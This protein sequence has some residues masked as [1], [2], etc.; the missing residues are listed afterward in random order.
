MRYISRLTLLLSLSVLSLPSS[1]ATS[2][3]QFDDALLTTPASPE[4]IA[5]GLEADGYQLG[6]SAYSW[7][8]PLVRMERVL[9]DYSDV[10]SEVPAT[11][12]RAPIS[13]IGWARELAS[14]SAKDMPTANNDTFYMS[15]VVILDEPFVLSVPD[16][17]DRYY[18]VNVFN[19]WQ[20]LEHYIGRRTTGTKAAR[21]VL[22]PPGWK[23]PVPANAKRLDVT[24][25]KVWLW[26]RLRIA[27]GEPTEPVLSLQKRFT[28]EPVS[29]KA[30]SPGLPALPSI[31]GDEL[32]FFK[33]LAFALKS[34]AVKPDDKALF[35]QFARMGLT[36]TGFDERKLSPDMR[37]GVLRALA[38]GPSVVIS[39]FASTSSVRNGWNWVTGL[40]S[41]GF[42]Y[43]LRAMIAGPYLGGNGEREAMYPIR[44]T[45]ADGAGLSGANKYVVTLS[46]EPPVGAFWSLTMYNAA[47]KM[48]VENAIQRYKVGTDTKGLKKGTDGSITIAV[49]N[50][51][52]DVAANVNWL[53]APKGDFYVILRMYQPSDAILDGTYQLPQ[54]T[55]VK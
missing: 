36:A 6:L 38:D 2:A 30:K 47:D 43:P 19:M 48:L 40:D 7:G 20:E 37:R 9:R 39:S 34:S 31:A 18:V 51:Q 22:V 14:P 17:A 33:H 24:T 10:S 49:Q 4:V 21:Y 52:P 54:M 12:Y 55:R 29:G 27:Q 41:F 13:R 46:K 50:E 11:S 23:G 53:P 5:K 35:A 16:T 26:G 42:N 8:Y 1:V 15:A 3:E 45:D 32:G 44:Y 28:L 25:N